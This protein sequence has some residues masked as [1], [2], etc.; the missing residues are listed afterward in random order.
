MSKKLTIEQIK[1]R[2]ASIEC[3]Y[4]QSFHIDMDRDDYYPSDRN[5]LIRYYKLLAKRKKGNYNG[6]S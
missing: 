2:I 1:E 4:P 5:N 3:C 6:L